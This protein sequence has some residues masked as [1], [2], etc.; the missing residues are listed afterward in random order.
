VPPGP[1]ASALL[2]DADAPPA[3]GEA[4]GRPPAAARDGEGGEAGSDD[5]GGAPQG[6]SGGPATDPFLAS[7]SSLSTPPVDSEEDD[8]NIS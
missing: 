2:A 8:E 1:L 3:S 7:L 6:G 4:D 5:G